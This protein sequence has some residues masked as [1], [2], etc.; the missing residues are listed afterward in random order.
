MA[1]SRRIANATV[2][3]GVRY[4]SEF[5][6]AVVC[7]LHSRGVDHQYEEETLLY[8]IPATYLVDVV[9]PAEMTATGKPI[10]VEIKG[11][12]PAE[13]KRKI[14]ALLRD[15]PNIDFRMVLQQGAYKRK[16]GLYPEARWCVKQGIV[17]AESRIPSTWL[18]K[19][20]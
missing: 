4:R 12:L 13:D 20:K 5:E 2:V 11:W 7:D 9:L 14:L 18:K 10:H 15:H 8:S 6:A 16:K 3:N 19:G 17:W 1:R